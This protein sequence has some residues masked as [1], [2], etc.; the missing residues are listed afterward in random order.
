[1]SKRL[2][3]IGGVAAGTS[4]ASR[5]RRVDADLEIILFEAGEHISYGACDEPYFI[6]GVIPSWE[7]L[8]VRLPRVFREK[9]NIDIRLGHEVTKID[10]EAKSVTVLIKETGETEEFNY[11]TLILATGARPRPLPLPGH[12]APNVFHLKSLDS[13]RAIDTFIRERKP[14]QAVS[15]GAG[16]INL[17]MAEA[18]HARG[19]ENTILTRSPLPAGRQFEQEI[20]ALIVDELR[21]RGVHYEPSHPTTGLKTDANGWVTAVQAG[22]DSFDADMVLVAIGVHPNVEIGVAAGVAVGPTGAFAVDDHLRTNVPDIFAAGDCAETINRING[23][24]AHYPLGDIANKHGWTAGENAAGGDLTY[25]GA[26][27]SF[28]FKCFELE[29]GVTGL[30][31]AQAR[32]A[33][34]DPLVN[35]I[36]HNSRAHAQPGKQK[37]TVRLVLDRQTG[38]ILGG[39]VAGKEGAALR[40]NTLAVA[41]HAGMTVEELNA[42]DFA[43][44]PPFSP[45][46]DPLLIAARTS[47]KKL[48]KQ[49]SSG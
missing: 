8:L 10:P 25:G 47:V 31:E 2:I 9:Q 43:Y 5:A 1:M 41:V 24:P 3:V 36:T 6:S 37:I 18:L 21:E 11:D 49:V 48:A 14:R 19:V 30:T 12:D 38:R 20:G 42:V 17:E 35:L 7:N 26:L 39:Q 4:A 16:F 28:H 23:Q 33:G 45:V 13:A 40:I 46:I 15:I 29:I 32:E 34:F 27:G 44:A 22:D